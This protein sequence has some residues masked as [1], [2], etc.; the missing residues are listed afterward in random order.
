MNGLTERYTGWMELIAQRDAG[1]LA[2][3]ALGAVVG[4][5][6]LCLVQWRLTGMLAAVLRPFIYSYLGAGL[7][8]FHVLFISILIGGR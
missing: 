2:L 6:L 5:V 7:I 8:A 4:L 1:L 3:F